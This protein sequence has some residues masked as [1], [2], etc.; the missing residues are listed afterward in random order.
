LLVG[1]IDELVECELL[2]IGHRYPN[3]REFLRSV[4]IPLLELG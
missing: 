4:K 2:V 1:S 3:V